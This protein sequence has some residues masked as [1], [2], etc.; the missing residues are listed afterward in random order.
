MQIKKLFQFKNEAFTAEFIPVKRFNF[1]HFNVPGKFLLSYNTVMVYTGSD[2]CSPPE[3]LKQN[4]NQKT[5]P[6]QK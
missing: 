6:I 3:Q 5:V 2:Q 1:A 4:A